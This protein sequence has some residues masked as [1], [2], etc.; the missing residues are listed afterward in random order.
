MFETLVFRW[1]E[2]FK[3]SSRPDQL[4]TVASNANIV[5]VACLIK[6]DARLTIKILLI[7][8]LVYHLGQLIKI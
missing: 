5:S 4:K 6:Q 3:D 7:V 2:K 1:H 8:V